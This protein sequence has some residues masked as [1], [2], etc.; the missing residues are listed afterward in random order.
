MGT[1][2]KYQAEQE[3]WPEIYYYR[4][5]CVWGEVKVHGHSRWK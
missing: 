5:C 2:L 1:D 4:L 3:S